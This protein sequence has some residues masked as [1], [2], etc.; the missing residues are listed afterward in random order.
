MSLETAPT[1]EERTV[2]TFVELNNNFHEKM[3]NK[4]FDEKRDSM[5]YSPYSI[6][7]IMTMLYR[8]MDGETR[9]E[10]E[11]VYGLDRDSGNLIQNFVKFDRKI[12]HKHLMSANAIF[13]DGQ[14]KENIRKDYLDRISDAVRFTL[15]DCDFQGNHEQEREMINEWV[16]NNT[17]GLI[18][19]LLSD[20][21]LSEDTRSV[22]VNTLYLKMRWVNPFSRSVERDFTRLDGT[23]KKVDMMV[24]DDEEYM[25]YYEND[26]LQMLMMPYR[27]ESQSAGQFSMG[28]ILPRE[29]QEFNLTSTSDV[30]DMV[31]KSQFHR[32]LV[33]VQV[34]KFTT[35]FSV[36]L[37]DMYKEFGMKTLFDDF[38]CNLRRLTS[39]NDLVVN[40]IIHKAKIIVDEMGTEA[41]A[42]TAVEMCLGAAASIKG[43][44]DF[45]ANRTFQYFIIHNQTKTILFSG[46]YN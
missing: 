38:K 2:S 20:N 21:S 40:K 32:E 22:L 34:P 36:E 19:D 9:E 11:R 25:Q 5:V 18:K 13:V 45:I 31:G 44:K 42:A 1:R 14:Y 4:L 43:P 29:G 27:T 28:I 26:S 23:T 30:E 12:Q 17:N 6:N 46:V 7:F 39:E 33:N 16:S 8:G 41:A 37:V 24:M 15:K 3:F 10:F 35:E